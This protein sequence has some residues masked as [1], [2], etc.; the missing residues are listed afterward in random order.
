MLRKFNYDLTKSIQAPGYEREL[1]RYNY[2]GHEESIFLFA[3]KDA[4]GVYKAEFNNDFRIDPDEKYLALERGYFGKDNYA[5]VI[6]DI[7]TLNDLLALNL[8]DIL[9]QHPD[10]IPGNFE[11]GIWTE[12]GKYL[13]GMIFQGRWTLHITA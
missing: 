4:L 13:Q 3:E 8:K 12:D 6:K 5:L 1:W 10:I 11:L 2:N 9:R 7:N